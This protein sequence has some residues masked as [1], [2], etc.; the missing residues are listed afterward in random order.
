M[1]IDYN[2]KVLRYK[3]RFKEVC[4]RIDDWNGC[5]IEPNRQPLC[6]ANSYTRIKTKF[7]LK[8]FNCTSS[9]PPVTMIPI[10]YPDF[11]PIPVSDKTTTTTTTTTTSSTTTT[12]T[13]TSRP[14]TDDL[15]TTTSP[16][17]EIVL[18]CQCDNVEVAFKRNCRQVDLSSCLSCDPLRCSTA[19]KHF[20]CRYYSS[21]YA[22]PTGGDVTT[23]SPAPAAMTNSL[24]TIY[25]VLIIVA[26]L[27]VF[28]LGAACLAKFKQK[29][30]QRQ[31]RGVDNLGMNPF[32]PGVEMVPMRGLVQ[33]PAGDAVA[34][35][36]F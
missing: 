1:I 14:T 9:A 3:K 4:L 23:A 27:F 6:P 13:T 28:V 8:Y 33:P 22:A 34:V 15:A 10:P 17:D 31:Y 24:P 16:Q 29:S 18:K 12:S 5:T 19:R 21:C 26:G 7:C 25:L 35:T 11:I 2:F 20:G 36:A 30:G 32:T